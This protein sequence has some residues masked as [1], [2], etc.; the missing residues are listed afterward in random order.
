MTGIAKYRIELGPLGHGTIEVNGED[1]TNKC[2]GVSYQAV[3]GQPSVLTLHHV[4][5]E[6][7]I[8]GEGIVR[9]TSDQPDISDADVILGFLDS[10]NTKALAARVL[11]S[12][13]YGG[14]NPIETTV[15]LLKVMAS[16]Y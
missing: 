9:V 11:E 7:V 3:T 8:E 6:G 15:A 4:G 2:Q 5:A 1:V 13:E 14:M 10:V 12:A 16:E